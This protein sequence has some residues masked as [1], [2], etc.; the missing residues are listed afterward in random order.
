MSPPAIPIRKEHPRTLATVLAEIAE[1][2]P[3][4]WN[5]HRLPDQRLPDEVVIPALDRLHALQ[6]EARS[7]IERKLGCSWD[8][9]NAACL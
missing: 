9:I 4:V 1:V 7:M 3:K 5:G 6:D 8:A 2:G